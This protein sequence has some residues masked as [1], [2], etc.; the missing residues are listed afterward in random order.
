MSETE[1]PGTP[2]PSFA[3]WGRRMA[4]ALSKIRLDPED[5]WGSA[6]KH[7]NEQMD[8]INGRGP[9]PR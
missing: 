7:F 3:E 4:E 2:V 8:Y 5:L 6:V 9:R 1:Q